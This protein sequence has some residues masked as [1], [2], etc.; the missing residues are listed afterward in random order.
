MVY[1]GF[2]MKTIQLCFG[3]HL[4][5]YGTTIPNDIKELYQ[6]KYKK[7]ISFICAHPSI[8]MS[9]FI[10]GI[11]L[12]WLKKTHPEFITVLSE[13]TDIGQI[14][15]LSGGFYEPIM[16]LVIPS[17]RV[18]QIEKLT[19]AIRKYIGKKPR[20]A[21]LHE[22]LWDPS[23]ISTFNT[24]A[25][26]YTFLDY[27]LIPQRRTQQLATFTPHIV[28][29]LGRTIS[30]IPIHDEYLPDSEKSASD[31]V[32]KLLS[33]KESTND[34]IV[35]GFFDIDDF[36]CLIET[37]WFS[38]LEA[39]LEKNSNIEFTLPNTFLRN[40][41]SRQKSY[42][43]AGCRPE[44]AA[45][46]VE[47]CIQQNN[48]LKLA[49]YPT[50]RDFISVY[51]EA[52]TLYSRLVH[53]T[54]LVNQCRDDKPRKIA[55]REHLYKAQHY[56]AYIFTGIGGVRDK[57]LLSGVYKNLLEAEKLYR[58]STNFTNNT[59]SVDFTHDGSKE[60][61]SSFETFNAFITLKGGMIFE[62]DVLK[63]CTN[64]SLGSKRKE[65]T[66]TIQDNYQKKL[67]IDHLIPQQDFRSLV[68][69][70]TSSVSLF[71]NEQYVE[72]SYNRQR[73][74]VT[75][76]SKILF[77]KEK[78]PVLLRKNFTINENGIL[79]QY[80][81]KNEGTRQVKAVFT[82]ENNISFKNGSSDTVKAEILTPNYSK[83]PNT[84]IENVFEND[85]S[86]VRLEDSETNVNFIFELNEDCTYAM[87]PYYTSHINLFNE[88]EKQYEAHS[89]YFAWNIDLQ[90]GYETEK[91]ISL[92]I[93]SGRKKLLAKKSKK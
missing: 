23:L 83:E 86:L 55:A 71:P 25:M 26:E 7:I 48:I 37:D 68:H 89:C 53:T 38:T 93:K 66:D 84:E 76:Q 33:I 40:Y 59:N 80:I 29:D 78:T 91:N 39:E 24:S 45:W 18:A 90:P 27:R 4:S 46:A 3:L 28:E 22:S 30:I 34:K 64:Y 35:A 44:V 15:L 67:F 63:D 20:G 31:Y 85:V 36:L 42:I 8:R 60:Y 1:N 75:L 87:N 52:F 21:F 92:T 51:N 77:G 41:P 50:A 73:N 54:M 82:I 79:V 43:P 74:T 65:K 2:S 32:K 62:L 56:S 61:L 12:D 70:G 88:I 49:N 81:L 19:T 47:P 16:P 9:L 13:K 17:D 5:N 58:Q 10:P 6:L 11:I 72:T 69:N 57:K 14:E